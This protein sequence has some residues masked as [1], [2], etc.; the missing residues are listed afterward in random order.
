MERRFFIIL[1]VVMAI[2]INAVSQETGSFTDFRDGQTYKTVIIGKQ[3]WMAENLNFYTPKS[4]Y[5]NFD[6]LEYSKY[7]RF[8]T[9][10]L[11][12]RV[13]PKGWHLPTKSEWKELIKYLGGRNLAA[14]KMETQGSWHNTFSGHVIESTN[15]SG[16]SAEPCTGFKYGN[17][18]IETKE[19]NRY[20][21][22][23]V[24][25]KIPH[26]GNFMFNS[27]GIG[28]TGIWWFDKQ[29]KGNRVVLIVNNSISFIIRSESFSECIRCLKD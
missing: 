6:S 26:Y 24:Y 1:T 14:K 28:R 5:Y 8:Y 16:F 19:I 27:G 21:N 13:C 10:D 2:A 4:Y 7:G 22:T 17:S 12:L 20:N 18:Y 15:S 9:Y 3:T 29:N 25:E 11:A 23:I